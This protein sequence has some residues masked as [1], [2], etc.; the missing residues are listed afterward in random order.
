[1]VEKR[2]YLK[3][4]YRVEGKNQTTLSLVEFCPKSL[5]S[6]FVYIIDSGMTIYQWNGSLSSL[7]HRSKANIL[8]NRLN[9]H[10]R[11]GKAVIVGIEDFDY[12]CE[13]FWELLGDLDDCGNIWVNASG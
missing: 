3:K 5:A 10:E 7:Q 8:C 4:M 13:S 12:S 1:M 6:D 2:S 9:D 11:L